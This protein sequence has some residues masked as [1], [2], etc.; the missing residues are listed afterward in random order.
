M[1]DLL[2]ELARGG[3]TVVA[4]LHDLTLAAATPTTSSCSRPA[5][6]S[7]RATRRRAHPEL[8]R[9]VYGVEATCS[10]PATG[11]PL[12]A[13]SEVSGVQAPVEP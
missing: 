6:S 13:F 11:R 5:G 3:L 10:P 9:D 2:R 4:A 7:R 12:I 1:L 8:M